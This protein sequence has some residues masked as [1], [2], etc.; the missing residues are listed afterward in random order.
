ML[1]CT[2][3][4]Q[5]CERLSPRCKLE[6]SGVGMALTAACKEQGEATPAIGGQG[7]TPPAQAQGYGKITSAAAAFAAA[8]RYM[9]LA[10]K[11]TAH[12]KDGANTC[13][14]YCW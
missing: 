3:H 6:D 7:N 5:G 1:R 13:R 4:G 9:L 10:C 8:A 2:C 14:C 12:P 11:C